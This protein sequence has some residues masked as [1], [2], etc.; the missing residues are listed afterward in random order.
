VQ[1][2]RGAEREYLAILGIAAIYVATL[3]SGSSFVSVSRDLHQSLIALQR[4]WNGAE[5][6]FS[7]WVKD[8]AAAEAIRREVN[9]I[10]P[11]STSAPTLRYAIEAT[12]EQLNVPVT[13]HRVV[14][15]RVC[16]V[17]DMVEAKIERANRNGELAWFNAAFRQWRLEARAHGRVMTYSEARAR[18]RRAVIER[19]LADV[20]FS[21]C[22]LPAVFPH[23]KNSPRL[24]SD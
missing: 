8:R 2:P 16:A 6:V 9:A 18:L 5:I 10:W 23:L 12:A 17:V 19:G 24:N 13:D 15:S 3:P 14:M 11:A 20:T 22:L 4:R 1:I 21:D 7:L